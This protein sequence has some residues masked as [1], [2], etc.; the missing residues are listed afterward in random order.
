[1]I[2]DP[3]GLV[4]NRLPSVTESGWSYIIADISKTRIEEVR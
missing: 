1:M 3:F 4:I 2:I